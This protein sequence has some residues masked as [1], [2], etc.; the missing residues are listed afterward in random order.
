M[1]EGGICLADNEKD[2]L[3]EDVSDVSVGN[4][5]DY[6]IDDAQ[7]SPT[8]NEQDYLTDDMPETESDYATDD[9]SYFQP[10]DVSEPRAVRKE[11]D[12]IEEA[13]AERRRDW[14]KTHMVYLYAVIGVV[15]VGIIFLFIHVYNQNTNPIS[16]F[17]SASSKNFG[18]SFDYEVT[19]SKNDESVMRYTGSASVNRSKHTIDAICNA[20]YTDYSYQTV[21]RADGE[22]SIKGVYY[23]DKWIISDIS[24]KIL[25][26]FD[27]DT[28]YRA[29]NFDSGSF[30]RFTGMTSDF[31]SRELQV[32]MKVVKE[33]LS[34]D[35]S[36]ADVNT[37]RVD[38]GVR[39]DY[40]I[41]VYELFDMIRRDGAS[42]FYRASDYDKFVAGFDANEDI[43][44]NATC[45]M[46][47][48]VNGQGY[49]EDLTIDITA[50]GSA[51]QME[52][53]FSNFGN[54]KVEIPNDFFKAADNSDV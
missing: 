37:E 43:I 6:L 4:E 9:S 40:D 30:L 49:L 3:T 47:F 54:A 36:I 10:I 48:F 19:L 14:V 52:C 50:N 34:T 51:Y 32:Y 21:I 12:I 5:Q 8:D 39:V 41:G 31:S 13:L 44:K 38:G 42:V 22:R 46:S 45:K 1:I 35:S 15:I 16:R 23:Q 26:F 27:F 25:D 24:E 53:H 11:I 29:G 33:R 17:I 18:G 7:D 2:K 20:E 28:D